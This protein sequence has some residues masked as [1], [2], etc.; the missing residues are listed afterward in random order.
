MRV[1]DHGNPTMKANRIYGGRAAG[2]LVYEF[3]RGTYADNDIHHNRG[4][5][6]EIKRNSAPTFERNRVHGGHPGGFYCH[7]DGDEGYDGYCMP[8]V[9]H[10][11][12]IDNE[13]PGLHV[14]PEAYVRAEGNTIRGGKAGLLMCGAR[15]RGMFVANTIEGNMDGVVPFPDAVPMADKKSSQRAMVLPENWTQI[16]R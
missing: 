1:Y 3:G 4:W 7:G 15:S 6:V 16:S 13:G 14:G 2:V 5:N 11:E 10:N 8:H 12:M 9:N